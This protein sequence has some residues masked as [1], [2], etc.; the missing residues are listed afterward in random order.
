MRQIDAARDKGALQ[1]ILDLRR[2]T[3]LDMSAARRLL[4]VAERYWHSGFPLLLAS[5]GQASASHAAFER[6]G[7]LPRLPADRV[8]SGLEEAMEQAE[9]AL[10][11]IYLSERHGRHEAVDAL[12]LL[13]IPDSATSAVLTLC[14]EAVFEPED[15]LIRTGDASDTL[16]VLIDGQVD[17]LLR[18]GYDTDGPDRR[19]RL[20][21]LMPGTMLGEMALLS[22]APR[23]ADAVA[24][25]QVRCLVIETAA[26]D[27]I[28]QDHPDA[29]YALMRA[30]ATHLARN[31]RLANET[32][33]FYED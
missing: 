25:T 11:A 28:R 17:I 26:V 8:F 21:T 7:L 3:S 19:T 27:Q 32:I 9:T 13:G 5:V 20:A 29:A 2:V 30:V 10:L 22:G 33:A 18:I 1:V 23:S 14:P 15:V 31:L 16:Y 24:R 4:Q 12:R 6:L